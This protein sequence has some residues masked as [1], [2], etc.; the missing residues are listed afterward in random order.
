MDCLIDDFNAVKFTHGRRTYKTNCPAAQRI[1]TNQLPCPLKNQMI[2]RCAIVRTNELQPVIATRHFSQTKPRGSGAK[3]MKQP[4]AKTT[5]RHHELQLHPP[6][7]QI[8]ANRI[9]HRAYHCGG[10]AKTMKQPCAATPPPHERQQKPHPP[11]TNMR[12]KGRAS[13]Q[14]TTRA[15]A[16]SPNARRRHGPP[17]I[18]TNQSHPAMYQSTIQSRVALFFI[19]TKPAAGPNG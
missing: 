9:R 11:H 12:T 5:R 1:A 3:A 4:C 18:A 14:P 13:V 15:T 16:A 17:H 6:H 19:A 8:C 7:Q 10:G 2:S